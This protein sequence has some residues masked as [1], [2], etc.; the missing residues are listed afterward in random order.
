MESFVLVNMRLHHIAQDKLLSLICEQMTGLLMAY[1][2]FV[3]RS[4]VETNF[5]QFS[6]GILFANIQTPPTLL[7]LNG[8]FL[9][10]HLKRFMRQH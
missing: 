7:L 9:M 1:F 8:F 2:F 10:N 3:R 5:I 6:N 4:G